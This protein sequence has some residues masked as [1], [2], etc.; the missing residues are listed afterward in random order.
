MRASNEKL[1]GEMRALNTKS[2]GAFR[3]DIANS[4]VWWLL[5]L[6]SILGVVG[7]ALGWF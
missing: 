2:D 5:I 7:K 6:G 1:S 3:V 4:K